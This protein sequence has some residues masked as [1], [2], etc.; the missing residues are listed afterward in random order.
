MSQIHRMIEQYIL[1]RNPWQDWQ[2]SRAMLTFYSLDSTS[3]NRNR[4]RTKSNYTSSR[5]DAVLVVGFEINE[6]NVF[7]TNTKTF[8]RTKW[9]KSVNNHETT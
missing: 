6:K 5:T 9:R 1:L 2:D 3:R 4:N 8:A 7:P